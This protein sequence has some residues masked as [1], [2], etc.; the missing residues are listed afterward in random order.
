MILSC[1]LRALLAAI[2]VAE[3]TGCEGT[4]GSG[5]LPGVRL[6]ARRGVGRRR[7]RACVGLAAVV[8]MQWIGAALSVA[9]AE[10]SEPSTRIT[11]FYGV[12]LDTMKQAKSLGTKGRYDRLYPVILGTFDVAGMTRTASG[13]GWPAASPAQQQALINAFSRMMTATYA[14]RFDDF[15]GERF[16]VLQSTDQPPVGTLVR[17]RLVQ[18]NGKPVVLNYLMQNTPEGWKIADVYL[19]GTISELAARRSEFAGVMRSGGPDALA[20]LLRQRAD[21]LLAP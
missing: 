17:T 4:A 9:G 21:K 10:Q 8:I 7:A 19:E 2:A 16:E 14:A 12:L 11:A 1:N 5:A 13:A 3:R 20:T 18:S 6:D 15:A